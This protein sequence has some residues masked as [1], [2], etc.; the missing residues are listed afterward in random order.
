[1]T[2]TA[3]L[4]KKITAGNTLSAVIP[5]SSYPA[6]AGWSLSFVLLNSSDK[7]TIDSTAEGGTHVINI[8][9]STTAG[10]AAGEYTYTALVSDGTDRHTVGS[11]D[12]EVLPDPTALESH[13]GRSHAK[14]MVDALEDLEQ[15]AASSDIAAYSI[16][17]RSITKLTPEER[18]YWLN[19]YKLKLIKERRGTWRKTI[20]TRFPE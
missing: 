12:V 18:V 11:G 13:D 16:A 3:T 5:L 10:Y 2:D 1:M 17:G 6:S 7:I 14:K 19:H 15:G 4:P 20:G 8:L 9:G